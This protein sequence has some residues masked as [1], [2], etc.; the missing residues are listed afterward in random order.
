VRVKPGPGE[1][2]DDRLKQDVAVAEV[3]GIPLVTQKSTRS[4][5]LLMSEG[6]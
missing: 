5:S 3:G 6:Q 4:G 1:W 2:S